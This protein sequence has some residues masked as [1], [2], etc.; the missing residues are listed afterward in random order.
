MVMGIDILINLFS[1]S[2]ATLAV[3]CTALRVVRST[4]STT[5]GDARQG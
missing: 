3:L 1:L 4:L 2:T 5:G